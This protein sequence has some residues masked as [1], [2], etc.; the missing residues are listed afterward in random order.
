VSSKRRK[1]ASA[2]WHCPLPV[3]SYALPAARCPLPAAR[4]P[5]PATRYPLPV[6]AKY[7]FAPS[8]SLG[9]RESPR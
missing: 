3:T 1:L 4:Y 8:T 5:L 6:T 2:R 9:G 7:T